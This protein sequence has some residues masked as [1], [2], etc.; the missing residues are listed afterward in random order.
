MIKQSG[1]VLSIFLAVDARKVLRQQPI[2][3]EG[4][5][6]RVYDFVK[7]EV[8][9]WPREKQAAS[10]NGREANGWGNGNGPVNSLMQ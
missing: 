3:P 9:Q 8:E 10:L 4:V 7:N 2:S 1:F 5:D 6:D